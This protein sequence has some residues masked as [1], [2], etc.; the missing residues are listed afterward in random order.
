MRFKFLILCSLIYFID[1]TLDKGSKDDKPKGPK[2]T[3]KVGYFLN[4]FLKILQ[5]FFDVKI[6]DQP[7]G[8]IVIGLFGKT[9]P[10]TVENF[11]EL[12]KRPKGVKFLLF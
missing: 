11:I 1:A 7:A 9:V 2:V 6:G 8:R 4:I 5:V 10:K 12:A 3:D